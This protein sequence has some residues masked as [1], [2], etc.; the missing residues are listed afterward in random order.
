MYASRELR[1]RK[2]ERTTNVRRRLI[3]RTCLSIS[4]QLAGY[5]F[6]SLRSPKAG[7]KIIDVIPKVSFLNGFL[8]L[9]LKR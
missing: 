1:T 5:L 9:L 4:C 7:P 8:S 2:T 3:R 6:A